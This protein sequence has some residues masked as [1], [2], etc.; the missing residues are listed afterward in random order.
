MSRIPKFKG[1]AVA[2]KTRTRE[3]D[4]HLG[5]RWSRHAVRQT[6][7]VDLVA[8]RAVAG[9]GRRPRGLTPLQCG[10]MGLSGQLY[11]QLTFPS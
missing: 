6:L 10:F 9:V 4:T 8:G 5:E 7:W 2:S 1:E 11:I 3:L